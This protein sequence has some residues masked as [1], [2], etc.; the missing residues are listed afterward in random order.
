MKI[1]VICCFCTNPIFGKNF[2]PK[3]KAKMFSANQIAGFLNQPVFQKKVTKQPNV[4][5]EI[6]KNQKMIKKFLAW[7]KMGVVN[8]VCEL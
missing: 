8:L 7:S 1:S 2:V 6:H 5:I 4:L 3:I